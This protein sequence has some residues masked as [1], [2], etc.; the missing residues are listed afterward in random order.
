MNTLLTILP[1]LGHVI[2]GFQLW[3]RKKAAETICREAAMHRDVYLRLVAAQYHGLQPP[4][5]RAAPAGMAPSANAPE[6][7]KGQRL[8]QRWQN[9]LLATEKVAS[10]KM[11]PTLIRQRDA[12]G[13]LRRQADGNLWGTSLGGGMHAPILD[14]DFPHT[15]VPS[16]TEGHGHLYVHKPVSHR[17]LGML[18]SLLNRMGLMGDGNVHQFEARG[19]LFAACTTEAAVKA[20]ETPVDVT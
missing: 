2:L 20:G 14:I 3:S 5:A 1:L 19:Q 9:D 17:Q 12:E 18:V 4:K 11:T 6:V 15:Y 13:N 16:K 10:E 8:R 7:V